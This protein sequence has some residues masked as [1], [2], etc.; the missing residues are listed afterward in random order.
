MQVFEGNLVIVTND[1]LKRTRFTKDDAN[2]DNFEMDDGDGHYVMLFELI[3]VPTLNQKA[4]EKDPFYK[5][6]TTSG[7][8]IMIM[9]DQVYFWIGADYMSKYLTHENYT[10]Q[11]QL[12]TNDLLLKLLQ[13][14]N[15]ADDSDNTDLTFHYMIEGKENQSFK[16]IL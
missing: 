15:K 6:L 9:N 16:T 8:F 10:S 11:H 4:R 5:S 12:I 7:L 3:G 2:I 14:Y 13:I 1:F